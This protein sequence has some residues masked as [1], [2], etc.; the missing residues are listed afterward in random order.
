MSFPRYPKYK[1]SGAPWLGEVP[2]HWQVKRLKYLVAN[3][4]GIQMGPFGGMLLELK[5]E[6]TG[7][8]VYGQENTISGN[9]ELGRK[10]GSRRHDFVNSPII[11]FTTATFS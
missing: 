10:D 4:G 7:F 6:D 11:M 2:A 8:K 9:F 3:P 1:D 5:S